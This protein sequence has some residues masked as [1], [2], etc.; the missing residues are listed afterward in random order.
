[1]ETH[2]TETSPHDNRP[3]LVRRAGLTREEAAEALAVHVDTI[4][5]WR[6]RGLL[7]STRPAGGRVLID[8]A[9]LRA[10]IEAAK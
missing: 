10:L 3:R 1:M 9:S 6:R 2:A 7:R 5:R 4:D 8:P